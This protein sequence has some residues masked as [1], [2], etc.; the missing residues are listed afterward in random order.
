VSIQIACMSIAQ[1]LTAGGVTAALLLAAAFRE[2]WLE[3][4][5]RKTATE[6]L[7]KLEKL[8]RRR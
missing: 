3:R 6:I 4:A 1:Q 8:K 2:A 5:R 7:D